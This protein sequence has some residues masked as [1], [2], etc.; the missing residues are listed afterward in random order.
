MS[1]EQEAKVKSPV[2]GTSVQ[3]GPTTVVGEGE[4]P[5]SA[6]REAQVTLTSSTASAGFD[7][8]PAWAGL[9]MVFITVNGI[10][11]WIT[12]RAQVD[13]QVLTENQFQV[14]INLCSADELLALPM[15][16][17]KFAQ[18][19]I[20]FRQTNGPFQQVDDLLLVDGMGEVKLEKLRPWLRAGRVDATNPAQPSLASSL[21]R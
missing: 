21:S 17:P 12:N 6:P 8:A 15:I 5:V 2:Q 7:P 13:S 10:G 18:R 4:I 1:S 16:G 20:V 19:I 14:D 9:M 3:D 11:Y